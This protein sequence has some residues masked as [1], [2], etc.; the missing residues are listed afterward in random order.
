MIPNPAKIT[1]ITRMWHWRISTTT[2]PIPI[3]GD[4]HVEEGTPEK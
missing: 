4:I 2:L 3:D 1:C